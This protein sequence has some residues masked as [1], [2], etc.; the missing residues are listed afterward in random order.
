M[1]DDDP[2]L[3]DTGVNGG[4]AHGTDQRGS[5]VAKLAADEDVTTT[6]T[7]T[8]NEKEIIQIDGEELNGEEEPGKSVPTQ[9]TV[10]SSSASASVSAADAAGSASAAAAAAAAAASPELS[11]YHVPT[12][13]TF[14]SSSYTY[15][16][17]SIVNDALLCSLCSRP[18]VTPRQHRCGI[19][20]CSNCLNEHKSTTKGT[21]TTTPGGTGSGGVQCKE[22]NTTIRSKDLV[23]PAK[24]IIALLDSLIVKCQSCQ[25]QMTRAAYTD[26]WTDGCKLS[27]PFSTYGCVGT[28]SRSTLNVHIDTCSFAPKSCGAATFGCTWNGQ[29][30]QL[31]AHQAGCPLHLALPQLTSI[32]DKQTDVTRRLEEEIAA[33]RE[34]LATRD[35][36]IRSYREREIVEIAHAQTNGPTTTT[37]IWKVGQV[38]DALDTEGSWLMARILKVD[39][40]KKLYYIHYIDWD[41][42]SA[43]THRHIR[44]VP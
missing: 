42:R 29:R 10:S 40:T 2:M 31:D 9:T 17:P 8:I 16:D 25:S 11:K 28:F 20:F 39:M 1:S 33:L 34:A 24:P 44:A 5:K 38:I 23:N 32:I 26:H 4:T 19:L 21:T 7:T 15:V 37:S 14:T 3:V 35:A 36:Q 22:C 6:T 18:L 27:C 13:P 30:D 41:S 43:D 12:D